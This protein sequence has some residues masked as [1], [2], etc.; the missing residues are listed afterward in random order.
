MAS[1]QCIGILMN[2]RDMMRNL[3]HFQADKSKRNEFRK[4]SVDVGLTKLTLESVGNV[5]EWLGICS[6]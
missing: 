6:N 5:G 2:Y 3:P 1:G 4:Q